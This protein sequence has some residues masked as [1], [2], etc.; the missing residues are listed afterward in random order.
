MIRARVQYR[1]V[2]HI[3]TLAMLGVVHDISVHAINYFCGWENRV[4]WDI[5]FEV[6]G[7]DQGRREGGGRGGVNLPRAPNLKGGGAIWEQT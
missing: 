2:T 7:F 4:L 1:A 6:M 5:A 3:Q